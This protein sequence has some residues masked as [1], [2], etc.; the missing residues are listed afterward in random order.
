MKILSKL[1]YF[2]LANKYMRIGYI[3]RRYILNL[4]PC[5][6]LGEGTSVEKDAKLL[7][8]DMWGHGDIRVCK[9]SYIGH[10]AQIIPAS[11]G[12]VIGD[13][14]T[15]NSFSIIYGQGAKNW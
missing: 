4:N 1:N 3:L 11:A 7:I 8:M 14:T 9:N 13:N 12:V 10:C 5:I 2:R 15:I 6:E